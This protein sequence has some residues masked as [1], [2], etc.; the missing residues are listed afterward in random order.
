MTDPVAP[1]LYLVSPPRFEPEAFAAQVRAALQGG[2]VACLQLWMPD[3][4]EDE[5]RTAATLVLAEVKSHDTA[6]LL[7]G[8][9]KL[10]AYLGC[11]GVHLDTPDVKSVKAAKKILGDDAIVGV[12]CGTS[13]HTSMDVAEAGADYVYFG[14]IFDTGTKDLP[15]AAGA[16]DTLT[17]WAEMMEVPCVAVGGLTPQ[18]LASVLETRC[19]FICAVSAVWSHPNGPDAAVKAFHKALEASEL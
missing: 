10:A 5:I 15:A 9:A 11:D 6:F 16:L 7:N 13:R 4:T 17:W 3:A 18:N 1:Q 8:N 12:S 2:P 19:E 14:P